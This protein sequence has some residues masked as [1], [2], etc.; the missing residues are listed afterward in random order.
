MRIKKIYWLCQLLGW[1]G[2]VVIEIINYTFFI[3]GKFKVEVLWAMLEL[4]VYGIVFTHLYRYY[5]KR[6]NFFQRKTLRI[7]ISTFL[8][9]ILIASLITLASYILYIIQDG[10]WI[11]KQITFINIA[12]SIMNSMRY[13]GVW[14]IIYFMYKLL[15]QNNA[16]QMSTTAKSV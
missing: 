9:T 11:L 5:L 16:I 3:V 6:T 15:Q 1:F 12:G 14:V 8:S 13:V 4:A 2:M 7:W 10:I